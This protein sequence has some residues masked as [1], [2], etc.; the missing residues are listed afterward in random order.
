MMQSS[1]PQGHQ[2]IA[3]AAAGGAA[4]AAGVILKMNEIQQLS[5]V[6]TV[7]TYI[8]RNFYTYLYIF[9]RIYF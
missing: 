5:S 2:Q 1:Q 9:F 3:T 6:S 8:H 7:G 4:A